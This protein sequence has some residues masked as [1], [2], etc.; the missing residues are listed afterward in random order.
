[1]RKARSLN[2]TR[3]TI[4]LWQ[5][6]GI[7]LAIAFLLRF[8][9]VASPIAKV[10]APNDPTMTD[11]LMDWAGI[12]QNLLIGWVLISL[13]AKAMA[14]PWVGI[15]FIVVGAGLIVYSMYKIYNKTKPKTAKLSNLTSA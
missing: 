8:E 4:R 9:A 13:G 12:S 2:I 10:I 14:F 11:K 7:F 3:P 5:I 1:M 15:P 6:L